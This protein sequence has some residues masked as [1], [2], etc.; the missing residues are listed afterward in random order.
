MARQR[1]LMRR[2][3]L[4][5]QDSVTASLRNLGVGAQVFAYDWVAEEMCVYWGIPDP[6]VR[7]QPFYK[8]TDHPELATVVRDGDAVLMPA[9][10]HPNVSIP[11]H[12]IGFLW[13][14]AGDREVKNQQFG[15]VSVRAGFQQ[16]ESGLEASR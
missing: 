5:L 16:G 3:N 1:R 12:R 15:G 10:Y 9:G 13:A 7:I 11:G 14:M 8:N 6:A 4:V 2:V